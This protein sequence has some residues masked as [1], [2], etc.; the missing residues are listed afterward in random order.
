MTYLPVRLWHNI[1]VKEQQPVISAGVSVYEWIT[2]PF[3]NPRYGPDRETKYKHFNQLCIFHFHLDFHTF[4]LTVIF[5]F[6]RLVYGSQVPIQQ[7]VTRTLVLP[8]L[9]RRTDG[10]SK[11][12]PDRSDQ[13]RNPYWGTGLKAIV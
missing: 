9:T 11:Q 1:R 13:Y 6:S 2:G 10:N 12:T 3:K 4:Q 7:A 8:D 5:R